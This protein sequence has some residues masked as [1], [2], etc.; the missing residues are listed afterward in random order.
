MFGCMDDGELDALF[1]GYGYDA[2]YRLALARDRR[3]ARPPRS[4]HRSRRSAPFSEAPATAGRP[5][6]PRWP[7]IVLR[8][9]KGWTGPREID[10]E[11]IEGTF[12]A[13]QVPAEARAHESGAPRGARELAALV[14]ARGAVRSRRPA[15]ARHRRAVPARRAAHG[16]ESAR[17]RRARA[18]AARVAAAVGVRRRRRQTR[19]PDR[20]G[21]GGARPIPA[22]GGRARPRAQ[23]LPHRLP[24]RA[25]VQPAGRGAR[26]DE[27]PVR[28]GRRCREARASRARAACSRCSRSISARAG[29]RA[30]C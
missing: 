28:S 13:H 16:D 7:M 30:T 24:G 2:A 25:R 17:L 22:R 1:T 6:A 21:H 5:S 11:Q 14:P 4:T 20:L 3:G 26:G 27:P 8:T 18:P 19:R 9:P 10:G 15:R 23:D 12:R 29:C